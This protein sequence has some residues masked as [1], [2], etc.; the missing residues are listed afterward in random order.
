MARI[1]V[2]GGASAGS[3]MC[4]VRVARDCGLAVSPEILVLTRSST[5][6]LVEVAVRRRDPFSP[7]SVHLR[8]SEVGTA[9][10]GAG[11]IVHLDLDLTS[12]EPGKERLELHLQQGANSSGPA[13]DLVVPIL[14]IDG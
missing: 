2:D 8:P 4:E 13:V 7:F 6:L 10:I 14:V 5:R 11:D 12:L 9:V 1:E 3:Y